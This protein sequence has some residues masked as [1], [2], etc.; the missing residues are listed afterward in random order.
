MLSPFYSVFVIM[1]IIF[2]SWASCP[3][4]SNLF[5][6]LSSAHVSFWGFFDSGVA[7]SE[8]HT[9]AFLRLFLFAVRPPL[10]VNCWFFSSKS[11][12]S[13]DVLS[14]TRPGLVHLLRFSFSAFQNVFF[15]WVLLFG[16]SPTL[17]LFVDFSFQSSARPVW[18][19]DVFFCFFSVSF[20][21]WHS[22]SLRSV[23][24]DLLRRFYLL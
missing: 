13:T 20:P 4:P 9:V 23:S 15:F 3:P 18:S 16:A 2:G 5:S 7:F 17:V 6:R 22:F 11:G 24:F 21:L 19:V 1:G 8:R 14:R 10:W 12:P